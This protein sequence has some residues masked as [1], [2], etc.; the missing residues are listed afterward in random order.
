MKLKVVFLVVGVLVFGLVGKVEA[1]N[2]WVNY[3]SQEESESIKAMV[4]KS[5]R[6]E[7]KDPDKNWKGI[8]DTDLIKD[9]AITAD[10]LANNVGGIKKRVYT[11]KVECNESFADKVVEREGGD[12][13]YYK[14]ID[15][16]EV[17]LADVPIVSVYYKEDSDYNSFENGKWKLGSYDVVIDDKKIWIKYAHY[18]SGDIRFSCSH[19]DYK[20]VVGY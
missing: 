8:I 1:S 18:D 17:D 7:F 4:K 5:I 3:F 6:N 12:K 19:E 9:G 10:K 14:E 13:E 15:V 16:N 20:I 2:D 11:L